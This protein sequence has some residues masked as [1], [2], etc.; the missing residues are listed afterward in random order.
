MAFTAENAISYLKSLEGEA[1]AAA[2]NYIV[3][4]PAS[5][6]TPIRRAVGEDMGW[7]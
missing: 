3:N 6:D 4:A 2:R 5:I 7:K 1:L